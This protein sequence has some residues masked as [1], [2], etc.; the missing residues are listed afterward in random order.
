L[1]IYG[2]RFARCWL[3]G[4]SGSSTPHVSKLNIENPIGTHAHGLR[5]AEAIDAAEIERTRLWTDVS[6]M[7]RPQPRRDLA[8]PMPLWPCDRRPAGIHHSSRSSRGSR[9]ADQYA[10]AYR[11]YC[12]P[13]MCVDDYRIA[14]FHLLATEG[15]VHMEKDHVWHMAEVARLV[16]AGDKIIVATANRLVDLGELASTEGAIQWWSDLIERGGEGMVA[17]PRGFVVRG[18][19]VWCSQPSNVAVGNICA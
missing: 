12:W 15:A 7:P 2:L 8:S 14:P 18:R 11:R 19:K 4:V 10:E 1:V 13:V 6:S 3:I 16:G 5:S 9:R 17:K